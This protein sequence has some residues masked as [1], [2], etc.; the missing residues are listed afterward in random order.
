MRIGMSEMDEERLL[1]E[2]ELGVGNDSGAGDGGGGD[3][4]GDVGVG[5]DDFAVVGVVRVGER[6]AAGREALTEVGEED[7]HVRDVASGVDLE[8]EIA[9]EE[10]WFGLICSMM[11]NH[12]FFLFVYS[13]TFFDYY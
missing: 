11:R 7:V 9:M 1:P 13:V 3:G 8:L 5:G 2:R 10:D 4:D 6:G 12:C